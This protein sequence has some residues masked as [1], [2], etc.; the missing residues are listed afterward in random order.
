M[1]GTPQGNLEAEWGASLASVI[2]VYTGYRFGNVPW[3]KQ[4]LSLII[5]GIL[6]VS[7]LP[8]AI[9]VWRERRKK[10]PEERLWPRQMSAV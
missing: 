1:A 8:I 7:V 3:V 4:N 2:A 6:V 9:K 10:S 5:A